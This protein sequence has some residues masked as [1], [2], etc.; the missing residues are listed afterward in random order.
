[1]SNYPDPNRYSLFWP[2][3]AAELTR[4]VPRV[5]VDA[6]DAA[7]MQALHDPENQPS[8]WGTVP[9]AMAK[10]SRR[11]RIATAALQAMELPDGGK[12]SAHHWNMGIP[13]SEAALAAKLAVVY[14]DA[15]IA[16]LDKGPRR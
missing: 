5:Q 3:R 4:A 1:M 16:E 6:A 14:A 12:Y 13:Q 2:E 15:L 11:E 9:V 7:L 8:Q 10:A